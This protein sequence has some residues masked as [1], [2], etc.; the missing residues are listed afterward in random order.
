VRERDNWGGGRRR[1]GE[2]EREEEKK[3][4]SGIKSHNHFLIKS[5]DV[6]YLTIL[7]TQQ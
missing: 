6:E 3:P 1:E 4:Q 2:R 7:E 5:F